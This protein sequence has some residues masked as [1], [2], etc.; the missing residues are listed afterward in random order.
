MRKPQLEKLLFFLLCAA[1]TAGVLAQETSAPARV[2]VP[3]EEESSRIL[4]KVPPVYPPLAR[5]AR[6]SGTVTLQVH[7]SGSGDVESVNLISGHPMLGP[8]AVATVK[9]WKYKPYVLNGSAVPVETTVVVNFTLSDA[10]APAKEDAAESVPQA[11][12]GKRPASSAQQEPDG[13]AR[14][15]DAS[16]M[17]RVA[18]PQRIRVSQG[19]S[20]GL[21]ISKVNPDYPPEARKARIEGTVLLRILIDKEGNVTSVKLIG[22]HPLLADA[23]IDAVK[24]WKYKPFLLNTQPIEVDTE[25]V[26]NFTL[27]EQ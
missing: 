19:I 14:G 10:T 3:Q 9:Q 12:T 26:V 25:V 11:E 27:K 23:A 6:V 1:W 5:Q 20:A 18:T 15:D 2:T 7:I 17:P 24:Q 16:A 13:V 22:G 8:A 4:S 21:L